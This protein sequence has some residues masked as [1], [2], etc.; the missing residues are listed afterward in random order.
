MDEAVEIRRGKLKRLDTD[1]VAEKLSPDEV[2]EFRDAFE[3]FDKNGNGRI[4]MAELGEMMTNLG[5]EVPSKRELED[6]LEE[7]DV[8]Q[9]GGIDFAEFLQFMIA[10]GAFG[11]KTNSG[12]LGEIF[13]VMD[14]DGDGAISADDLAKVM[15]KMGMSH[16][17]SDIEEMIKATGSDSGRVTRDQFLKMISSG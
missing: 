14:T 16:S 5:K 12:D 1:E 4:S 7:L 13:D 9:S 2:E 15:H 11:A 6:I 10:D 8:D 17:G 3:V